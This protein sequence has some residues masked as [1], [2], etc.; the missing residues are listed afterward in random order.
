MS[1]INIC[2]DNTDPFYRYKMP[3][4]QSKIEGRG[5]GIKT[6]VPNASEVARALNRPPAYVIKYF[7]FELGALTSINET[8]DRYLV[9]GAHDAAKLQDLLDGFIKKFVLCPSCSNPE[10]E[11]IIHKD[12]SLTR[13]C[14]ACGKISQIDPRHKL[15][16][17]ILKNPPA[18]GGKKN[19]KS[20]TASENVVGGGM[21]ISDIAANHKA[22]AKDDD[23]SEDELEAE[24][25]PPV[26][27]ID[28][29]DDEW[30]VDVSAEAVK[31]R[32]EAMEGLTATKNSFEL[33]G[34]WLLAAHSG[35]EDEFPSDVEIYKKASDLNIVD[36]EN[37]LQVL[38]QSLFS[39]DI[40]DEIDEHAGLL[41]KLVTSDDHEKALLG[42]FERLLGLTYPELIPKVPKILMELY[43]RDILSEDVI[44]DWGT[45]VSKK[46]VPKDISKKVRKAAKP[47]LKW[48]EEAES[49]ED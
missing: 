30:A 24:A 8:S 44:V 46:Y 27:G 48:L 19:K 16:T 31:A 29:K 36:D 39:E 11:I 1:F 33:L 37:T 17:Y 3:P 43:D 42:G 18:K 13:D 38:A 41:K 7:G 9:N 25:P 47:F 32:A 21:S 20:A 45:K 5:N 23:A 6:A 49:E 34:E 4:I 2:R 28:V 10:T 14:K 15:A 12:D 35:D 22:N 40:V 26:G